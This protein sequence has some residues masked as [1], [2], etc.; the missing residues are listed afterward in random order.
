MDIINTFGTPQSPEKYLVTTGCARWEPNQLE[1]EIA[2]NDWLVV[3]ADEN[4]LFDV[5]S[6]NWFAANQLLGI[7]HVNFSYQQQMEHS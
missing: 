1:N 5:N 4:I 2:N 6:S 3:P 7:E